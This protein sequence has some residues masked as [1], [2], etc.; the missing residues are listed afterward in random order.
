MALFFLLSFYPPI[1]SS[2]C[3]LPKRSLFSFPLLHPSLL[4]IASILFYLISRINHFLTSPFKSFYIRFLLS[5]VYPFFSL[6]CL[7]H[8]I[9]FLHHVHYFLTSFTGFCLT[10]FFC[11]LI[12][13]CFGL[14]LPYKLHSILS[15]LTSSPFYHFSFFMFF[16]CVPFLLPSILFFI[17][18]CLSLIVTFLASPFHYKLYPQQHLV[19]TSPF[20][21]LYFTLL[22]FPFFLCLLL[23]VCPWFSVYHLLHSISSR[24]IYIFFF[25]SYFSC[26]YLPLLL[27]SLPL[28]KRKIHE[29]SLPEMDVRLSS[30]R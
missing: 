17:S 14:T 3:I 12:F 1:L 8:S 5:F 22:L 23:L 9:L 13:V 16:L 2:Y 24:I 26:I 30:C 28:N 27:S 20:S 18:V 7:F 21:C 11:L 6:S 10:F 29:K 19:L 15:R 25:T 4:P